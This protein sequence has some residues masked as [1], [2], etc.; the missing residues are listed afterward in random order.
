MKTLVLLAVLLGVLG[1]ATPATAGDHD[2]CSSCGGVAGGSGGSPPGSHGDQNRG[3]VVTEGVQF[4][5]VDE[6]TPLGQATKQ[7]ATCTDCQWTISPACMTNDPMSDALCQ[8]AVTSCTDPAIMFRVYMRHAGGPWQLIDTVCLGANQR[9]A[10]VADVG[11]LVRERVVNYLPDAAP[12]FQPA[13]G[14]LVNLPTIF[15]AGE[16]GSIRTEAF[17]ILGFS[18]VVTAKARWE[19]RFDDG[20]TKPFTAPGGAYPND[21][22]SYTYPDAGDRDVS[23]TTYWRASFTI[24]G[25]GPFQ[26]PGAEISKTAG[27][28][29]VPV[30]EARSELVGG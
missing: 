11:A 8:N 14:G 30:R 16:P 25:D 10:S 21:D 7:N 15:A 1:L 19:W 26:V 3:A 27:P 4:P 17:D 5:G 6:N 28:I 23:V 9:P 13:Q 24:D 20:V 29:A 2:S 22:V 12:S 18:V